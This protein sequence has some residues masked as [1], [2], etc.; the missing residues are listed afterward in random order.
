MKIGSHFVGEK[1]KPYETSLTP[2]RTMNFAAAVGDSSTCYFDDERQEGIVAPPMLSTSLCWEIG[3]HPKKYWDLDDYP[4][5]ILNRQVHFTEYVEWYRVLRPGET[6]RVQGEIAA[7]FPQ[8]GGT[9]LVVRYDARDESG[10]LVFQEY[11]GALL[12]GVRCTDDGKG[13][14]SLPSPPRASRVAAPLWEKTLHVNRLA[15]HVYDGCAEMPFEI[16][17]SARFAR[18]VGLP[19]TILHGTATLSYAVREIVSAET[20]GNPEALRSLSCVFSDKVFLDT[21]IHIRLMGREHH[22]GGFALFFEVLNADNKVA[23]RNGH[24]TVD[25]A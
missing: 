25:G 9:L 16:Q 20:N 17:T 1:S 24:L 2:R 23:I 14:K 18:S 11:E 12:R 8:R 21:D 13:Q 10:N 15:A 7:I 3:A 19:D 5:E 4:W 6:I 22:D